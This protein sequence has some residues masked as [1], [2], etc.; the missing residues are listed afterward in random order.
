MADDH[1]KLIKDLEGQFRPVLDNSADGVYLWLDE[2]HMICNEKLAKMFGYKNAKEFSR[3]SPFLDKFVAE[4]DQEM[5]SKQ[6]H[7]HIATLSRPARFRF[8]GLRKG[9]QKFL[10]ETDMIPITFQGHAIAYHFVRKVK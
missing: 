2:T 7:G 1:G 4:K 3:V 8:H 10:A 5:F 9:G 6:Y